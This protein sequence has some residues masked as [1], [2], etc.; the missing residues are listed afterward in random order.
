[1]PSGPEVEIKP[2]WRPEPNLKKP[3]FEMLE[4]I[5]NKNAIEADVEMATTTLVEIVAPQMLQ[6]YIEICEATE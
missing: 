1:M 6:A 4:I 3:A 5:F 2:G